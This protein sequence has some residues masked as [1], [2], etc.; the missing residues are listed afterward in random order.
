MTAPTSRQL[1]LALGLIRPEWGSTNW[2]IL[3]L[4]ASETI[5]YRG[6]DSFIEMGERTLSARSGLAR[7][8]V[9]SR[10]EKLVDQG[11]LQLAEH[12]GRQ[13]RT[14]RIEGEFALWLVP[15][16]IDRAKALFVL[17]AALVTH[18]L[19]RP[20]RWVCGSSFDEP[21]ADGEP[22]PD[23]PVY[24][25]EGDFAPHP[26][27]S[28]KADESGANMA[29]PQPPDTVNDSRFSSPSETQT[30]SPQEEERVIPSDEAA[31]VKAVL[32]VTGQPKVWGEP[33]EQIR[34]ALAQAPGCG[35]GVAAVLRRDRPP[36]WRD[37]VALA[38]RTAISIRDARARVSERVEEPV[39][40]EEVLDQAEQLARF[41][42]LRAGPGQNGRVDIEQPEA[43]AL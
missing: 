36:R 18:L 5:A 41:K 39:P 32:E 40:P 21:Q 20:Q 6:R 4:I 3:G 34:D 2:P 43:E 17:Q 37:A 27:L 16:R 19:S 13:G 11:V 24:R 8:T 1:Y 30:S 25:I 14:V 42:Q 31:V 15:W 12:G 7:N 22:A 10:L 26:L 9:S 38:V 28:H 29:E 33:L 23:L 35:P